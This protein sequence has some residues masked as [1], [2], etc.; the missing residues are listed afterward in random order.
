MR[1]RSFDEFFGQPHL[2]APE[3]AFRRAVEADRL[4]SVILWGPPGVGKT[5]LADIVARVTEARFERVSAVSAGVADLRKIIDEAKSR[6]QPKKPDP[7][8]LFAEPAAAV[9]STR[10]I[11]FI[12]EI[13]RFNK[14]QQDAILPFVEN[15]VVTLIGATTENPSFEVNSA[16]LSRCRVFVLKALTD[17]EIGQVIRCA[18]EDTDR[19]LGDLDF[20]VSPEALDAMVG[21]ANGD[22]RSALNMLELCAAV[23]DADQENQIDL[24]LLESAV[25]RRLLL[26]DKAG[27]QHFDLISAL[28][29]T[30]RGSDVDASLYWLARM[31]ESG[32]DP[33][34]LARRIVRM[35]SEDIG[36]ADP[37]ALGVCMAAQ[38]AIHFVG[39]PEGALALA[40]AVAYLAL[41]PKSNALYK[42][43]GAAT[44]DVADT[45]N[46]PVPLHLR[47]APTNLMKD[48][49]YG[50]GYRYAHDY[51][52]AVVY[53]QNLPESLAGRRY[54]EP[55]DRGFETEAALRIESLRKLF[56][57]SAREERAGGSEL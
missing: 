22:A 13:H 46:D 31:L 20:Q 24:K 32:E 10:T 12:D 29:K 36:L 23:A 27:E 54:Y 8:D 9:H 47:N 5:T 11:L 3:A 28:H 1:P 26:Y 4:G 51:E 30:V 50:A 37:Q 49:G 7:S 44:H 21:L 53:Q 17:E 33:L 56:A 19:G 42:A 34:Y 25:Q 55:T 40:Q 14:A 35:A 15:G 38:Q 52:G 18:L 43:Y 45:R 41:A 6:K 39:M 16:V 48:L 2:V 57:S